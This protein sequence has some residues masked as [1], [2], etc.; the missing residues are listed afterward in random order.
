MRLMPERQCEGCKRQEEWGCTAKLVRKVD[1]RRENPRDG[2]ENP[3]N[4]PLGFL[5]E[6]IWCCP[7][8]V[9]KENPQ[10]WAIILRYYAMYKRGFLPQVGAV[11]DQSH[12]AVEVFRILDGINAECDQHLAENPPEKKHKGPPV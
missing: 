5:G 8:Q 11:M 6:E 9:V 3:S 1:P 10:R 12:Y 7:R 2:W 4:L